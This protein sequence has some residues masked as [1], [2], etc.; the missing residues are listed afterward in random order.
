MRAGNDEETNLENT[1]GA[2]ATNSYTFLGKALSLP[3]GS[4]HV[5]GHLSSVT[6]S[7]CNTGSPCGGAA[8]AGCGEIVQYAAVWPRPRFQNGCALVFISVSSELG[9][10]TFL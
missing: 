5:M 10:L 8:L 4:H 2:A 6:K 3:P 7:I 1:E 9:Q